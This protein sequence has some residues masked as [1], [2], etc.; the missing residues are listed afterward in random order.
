MISLKISQIMNKNFHTCFLE[1]TIEQV[2]SEMR[3]EDIKFMIVTDSSNRYK[4]IVEI[5]DILQYVLNFG[6]EKREIILKIAKIIK[7]ISQD[8]DVLQ[9]KK[10]E[11]ETN[12]IPVIDKESSIVGYINLHSLT[13]NIDKLL[14][15]NDKSFLINKS[16]SKYSTKYSI[17]NFIGESKTTLFL[18]K[19]ILTAARTNATILI[20]GETGTGKE[21]VAHSIASLS[22]RRHQPFV[23][24][25]CA[26]IPDNLL[27]S[28][29]FGY[30]EGAFTGAIKGGSFGKFLQANN[31]TIFL[32]EIGDMPFKLQAK[33]LRVLQEK[34]IERIGGSHPVPIDVRIISATHE[35][36][37]KL[38][39]E[40]RFRKDLFY[41]L[42]VIP[43]KVPALRERKEDISMLAEYFI[44]KLSRELEIDRPTIDKS[45]IKLLME[46]DWPG[47][48]RELRNILEM[49]VSFSDGIITGDL[50][51]DS[52]F[53]DKEPES[54]ANNITELRAATDNIEKEKI[55]EIINKH[56]GNKIKAAKELGISRSNLYYKMKKYGL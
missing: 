24:I 2:E 38:V 53:N 13:K 48:V 33:I 17:D 46:Y 43:I 20:M 21:L 16:N 14:L 1:D 50:V 39:S 52:I 54:L 5:Q 56:K 19:Q 34:E 9:V 7:C 55:V 35:N 29:L 15:T 27:E 37:H 4:G 45:F 8:Y 6:E 11:I 32:D 12:I 40:N 23:R 10:I 42:H 41:R 25:N 30:E 3:A 47:N 26:A 28:E 18:K 51:K 44:D 22:K 36:L 31:G 49:A